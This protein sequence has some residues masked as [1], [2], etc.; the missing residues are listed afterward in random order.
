ME[1]NKFEKN[2]QH[3]L[4]E[5]KIQPS[6]SVWLNVEKRI[7]KK[8]QRRR[9]AFILFFLFLILLSGSYWLFNSE[10]ENK[11]QSQKTENI[12]KKNI[13]KSTL[14]KNDSSLYQFKVF[15]KN[16]TN[17]SLSKSSKISVILNEVNQGTESPYKRK[18]KK[19][20]FFKKGSL[21]TNIQNVSASESESQFESGDKNVIKLQNDLPG[22]KKDLAKQEEGKIKM[23]IEKSE[24]KNVDKDS[25]INLAE[26]KKNQEADSTNPIVNSKKLINSINKRKWNLGITLSGGKSM[27]AN[28]PLGID[29][30]SNSDYL[31]NPNQSSGG[32]G[33]PVYFLNSKPRNSFAFIGG[34]L[35]EKNIFD[36]QKIIIGINYKYFSTTINVGPKIDS[37][38][39]AYNSISSTST[40][41]NFRN[42][43]NYIELPVSL[44]FQLGN[45]KSLPIYWQAG[46]SFSQLISSNALQYKSNPGVYYNDNSL[47]NKTQ[48]GL[49]TGFSATLF[50]KQKAFLNIGP[51]FYYGT[52]KLANEGLYSKK[53]FSFIGISTEFLFNKK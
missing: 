44:K 14:K 32:G 6:G 1:Q 5:L 28:D 12:S 22:E 2:V 51:Y 38:Q 35:I 27:V 23:D 3:K 10:K 7:E 45:S 49:N 19:S 31:S 52:S 36:K 18:S 48:F 26:S 24:Q 17:K 39:T 43:F 33:V 15:D 41:N 8:N 53:H 34:V 50:S 4:D 30:S 37:I 20:T 25:L 9:T 29:N 21:K 42:N 13:A 11:V 40:S 16:Y 47:F 46:I